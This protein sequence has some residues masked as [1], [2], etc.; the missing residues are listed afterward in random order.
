MFPIEAVDLKCWQEMLLFNKKKETRQG[1]S[2]YSK[3]TEEWMDELADENLHVT[4][5]TLSQLVTPFTRRPAYLI[6]ERRNV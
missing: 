1:L 3:H 4:S 6:D 5:N 2:D